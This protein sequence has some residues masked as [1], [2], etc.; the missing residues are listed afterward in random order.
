MLAPFVV[1]LFVGD[2]VELELLP[3]ADHRPC[4]SNLTIL[5]KSMDYAISDGGRKPSGFNQTFATVPFFESG[6]I[7]L[8]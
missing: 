3:C 6:E 5:M 2:P 8:C 7:H 1:S 4:A